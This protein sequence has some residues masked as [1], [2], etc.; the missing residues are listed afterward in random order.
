L[1]YFRVILCGEGEKEGGKENKNRGG[2]GENEQRYWEIKAYI[3]LPT[4]KK[5][6]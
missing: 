3:K 4:Q 5:S 1:K 2:G 6:K